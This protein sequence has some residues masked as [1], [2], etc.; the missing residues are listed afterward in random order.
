MNLMDKIK[1]AGIVGCGGAVFPTH[2]KLDCQV[3][4]LIVNAAQCEPLLHTDRWLV[5]YKGDEIITA[6]EAVAAEIGADDCQVAMKETHV[7][8]ITHF[9]KLIAIRNSRIKIFAIQSF[10]P[11]GDEQALAGAV[12]GKTVPPSGLPRD[13]DAVVLNIAT[14]YEIYRAMMGQPFTKRLI[15]MSGEINQPAILSAPIGTSFM[16]CI[17]AAGKSRL[18]DYHV[19]S[20]G[21]MMGRLYTREEAKKC[22]VTKLTSGILIIPNDTSFLI[23]RKAK[24]EDVLK[25]AK[26]SCVQCERCTSMCPRYLSGHPIKPHMIIR[27]LA[28][29]KSY[30]EILENEDLHQASICSECGICEVI[31]CPMGLQPRQVNRSLKALYRS[32]G[33]VYQRSEDD[34]Y[35][36]RP[37]RVRRH[38]PGRELARR[39][40]LLK[41]YKREFGPLIEVNANRV[42]ISLKQHVGA[43]AIPLVKEGDLVRCGQLIGTNQNDRLSANIHASIDGIVTRVGVKIVIEGNE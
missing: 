16:E 38:V 26:T 15:T 39:L 29:A 9:Q 31:A 33:I 25:R 36:V 22:V 11:V 30:Q 27:R 21:P 1:E 5:R 13:I 2:V 23:G 19:I 7:E 10:Y 32:K 4:H 14:T 41:Y 18:A 8:E 6:I 17:E 43:P 37:E 24:L 34:I 20:G 3:K 12:T 28:Y 42:A 35:Q 40:G